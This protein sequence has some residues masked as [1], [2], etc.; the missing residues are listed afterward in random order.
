[1]LLTRVRGGRANNVFNVGVPEATQ[2]PLT[3]VLFA[4][5]ETQL[6]VPVGKGS[7]VGVGA[8]RRVHVTLQELHVV[9]PSFESL[10]REDRVAAYAHLSLQPR[11]QKVDKMG[12]RY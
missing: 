4:M 2:L 6:I 8:V 10:T 9:V 12:S 1:M 5:D 11:I 3:L 7:G